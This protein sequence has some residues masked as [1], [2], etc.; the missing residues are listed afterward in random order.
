L[1]FELYSKLDGDTLR[2]AEADVKDTIRG[3]AAAGRKAARLF[4]YFWY[5][6]AR[7]LCTGG[8]GSA[9]TSEPAS[10]RR[11]R[12]EWQTHTHRHEAARAAGKRRLLFVVLLRQF[13]VSA[14]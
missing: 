5:Y 6:I 1:E 10:A 2:T 11:Y 14:P 12:V 13:V 9:A 7:L 8:R 4:W 3:L